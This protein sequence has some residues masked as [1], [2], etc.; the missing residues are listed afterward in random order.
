[1]TLSKNCPANRLAELL[2]G[3]LPKTVSD[4]VLAH[5]EECHSCR[6][7]LNQ[8][9]ATNTWWKRASEGL[10]GLETDADG[11]LAPQ[12]VSGR[13]IETLMDTT[14]DHRATANDLTI[15]LGSFEPPTHPDVL[16][17]V[18]EFDVEHKIGQGGM[19]VVFRGHDR[20]LNRPVAIKFMAPYL[21]S[22]DIARQR[23]A[24]EARAAAAVKSP[25][26]V[27]IYRVSDSEQPYIAM[28][29]IDGHSL[30]EH[31]HQNGSLALEDIVRVG[32]QIAAGLRDAHCQG[33]IHRDIKPANVLLDQDISR[34]MITDF[35]LAR[36][37]DDLAMT[38]S[39]CLAGTP[40]YM[41]PEQITDG[42]VDH[43][44]DL[45]SLGGLLYFLA[46]EREPFQADNAFSAINKIASAAVVSARCFNA[47]LPEAMHYVIC[48]LLEK[49]PDDRFQSAEDVHQLLTKYLAHLRA[50]EQTAQ[51]KIRIP[52]SRRRRSINRSLWFGAVV[53]TLS[54]GLW[55]ALPL[56]S[57]TDDS[58]KTEHS[59]H[60]H[61]GADHESAE[62]AD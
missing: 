39:G 32:S 11:F 18:D 20:S 52:P 9:A 35:G 55:A 45:F 22:D 46:T 50:P 29:L 56:L 5:V 17:C 27:P 21:R 47:S 4:V 30:Q 15:L 42:T 38:Q 8:V 51:P 24:R 44:S 40:H 25:H 61:V 7:K 34:V 37:I 53:A 12:T 58:S 16:G 60:E 26:V 54:G 59:N 43:R 57:E 49:D 14:E 41:S 19:G 10:S 48:R 62:H 31:V 28:A 2:D 36:A 1:M 3:S 13:F 23:F 33:V 6:E